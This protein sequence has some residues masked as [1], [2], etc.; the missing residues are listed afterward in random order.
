[1]GVLST[2]VRIVTEVAVFAVVAKYSS[3][4]VVPK[5]TTEDALQLAVWVA[6]V[7]GIIGAVKRTHRQYVNNPQCF[8]GDSSELRRFFDNLMPSLLDSVKTVVAVCSF[9]IAGCFIC[10][11]LNAPMAKC[12]SETA[13]FDSCFREESTVNQLTAVNATAL[14]SE[15]RETKCFREYIPYAW[16][17]AHG[18]YDALPNAAKGLFELGVYEIV[19]KYVTA[20]N[21]ATCVSVPFTVWTIWSRVTSTTPEGVKPEGLVEMLLKEF[22]ARGKALVDPKKKARSKGLVNAKKRNEG[23]T[24]AKRE[25]DPASTEEQILNKPAVST[26]SKLGAAGVLYEAE[27]SSLQNPVVVDDIPIPELPPVD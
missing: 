18:A 10:Y 3:S 1:M 15:K 11:L 14:C 23:V 5:I 17:V 7:I 12:T 21:I 25:P 24:R 6:L 13:F 4:L 22:E 16:K 9:W 26:F 8:S 20:Q 2:A 19:Q 27:G